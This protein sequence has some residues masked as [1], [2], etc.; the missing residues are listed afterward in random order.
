MNLS[1]L[2]VQIIYNDM[3]NFRLIVLAT[4]SL[5]FVADVILLYK[6]NILQ[7]FAI[8]VV[9]HETK[10]YVKNKIEKITNKIIDKYLPK[11]VSD[12]SF[13]VSNVALNYKK[14]SDIIDQL[15]KW[16]KEAPDFT[17]IATYG[18]TAN[19]TECHYFRIGTKDKPKVLINAGLYGDEEYAILAT[20]H[21]IEKLLNGY[22]KNDDITWILNN[23][24]IYFIPTMS[25][26]TYL[27]SDK[28]EGYNPSI[29]FP[30]PKRPNN[31]SPSPIK[32][33]MCL[34]NHM[35]FKAVMN[36]H[37]FGE[38]IYAPE[39][40][41]KE[42]GDKINNLIAKM[43]G[44]NGYKTE[45]LENAQGS[46]TDVDWFYSAG[47]ASIKMMWGK[48]SRQFVEYTEVGPSVEK[49]L[50]AIVLF[51]KEAADLNLCPTPLHT[52]YYYEAE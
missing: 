20:M 44:I 15:E 47:S 21:T 32:L 1:L 31:P 7:K 29:S 34:M 48:K 24:D 46:G 25:P 36:M 18:K 12:K 28:I 5:L 11:K 40:C 45:R 2:P 19:G 49:S 17:D 23:R 3:R 8:S 10:D 30:Y 6:K 14:Q 35:K 26:D 4:I 37:T 22:G 38:S 42:D 50:P 41:Q 13:Q 43:I 51:I 33:V 9:K 52:V 27:K 39:I 16:N